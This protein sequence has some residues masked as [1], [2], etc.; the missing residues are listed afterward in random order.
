MWTY[1]LGGR[2]P[3]SATGGKIKHGKGDQAFEGG[4]GILMD[5]QG[6]LH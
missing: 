4:A 2:A 1:L 3:Y 6:R 5:G